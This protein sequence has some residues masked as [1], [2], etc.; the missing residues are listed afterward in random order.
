MILKMKQ[1]NLLGIYLLTTKIVSIAVFPVYVGDSLHGFIGYDT[2]I[3]KHTF[4]DSE[5]AL[6]K[7][8][9]SI[10]SNIVSRIES[11]RLIK[12]NSERLL[13][14]TNAAKIAYWEWDITNDLS[15][16][17]EQYYAIT[18]IDKNIKGQ[19]YW[20]NHIHPDDYDEYYK[21]VHRHISGEN[22]LYDTAFRLFNPVHDKYI[23]LKETGKIVS[24]NQDN[25]PS[26]MVGVI[27]D[28][29]DLKETEEQ[30]RLSAEKAKKYL[31][32]VLMLQRGNTM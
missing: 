15:S 25:E 30:L 17:N 10:Y 14:S 4:T 13:L 21:A 2:E 29:T 31:L 23:W 9:S 3:E 20:R 27:Q 8:F 16:T 12:E 5:I 18:G 22:E 7:S 32:K 6:L 19:Q 11:E 28:I 1:M 26:L 24:Y